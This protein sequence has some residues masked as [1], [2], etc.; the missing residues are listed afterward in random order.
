MN[1]AERVIYAVT[2][3]TAL[4]FLVFEAVVFWKRKMRKSNG[5]T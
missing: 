5:T 3:A 4:T 2:C 1:Y